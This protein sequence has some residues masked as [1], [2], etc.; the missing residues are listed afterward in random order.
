MSQQQAAVQFHPSS[1]APVV[2]RNI[3]GH[4]AEHLGRCIYEGIWVGE[5]SEIPNTRGIRNDVVAALRQLNIPVLRWPGGCF[6][7]EYHWMDGIGPREERPGIYNSHWGGVVETNQFGTHE[8]L[9]LCEMLETDPYICGNVGSGT[10]KE[11]QDWV[12]YMTSDS[13]SPMPNLRRKNGREKAWR[14]PFFGVGNESWGC[15]GNMRPEYYANEYRRYNTFV[16]TYS[17]NKI[18]RIACGANSTDTNWTRVLMENAHTHMDGLALHKYTLAGGK[19]P[20]SGSAIDFTEAGWFDILRESVL[21]EPLIQ[22]HIDEMDKVD[23]EKRVGMVIDEWGTWF[24]VEPGTNPGFLYQQNALRDA[25][26]AAIHFHIFHRHADRISMANIAQTVNV[27]QAMILTNGP[28]MIC[29]PTYWVFEMFKVHQDSQVIPLTITS[30]NYAYAGEEIPAVSASATV[31]DATYVSLVNVDPHHSA[32][33]TLSLADV[34]FQSGRVLTGPTIQAHN[35]FDQP[36]LVKPVE[37]NAITK[38]DGGFLVELPP[39]S[40]AVL[41]FA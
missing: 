21:I 2:N 24:A 26:S 37:F 30:D 25:V 13:N 41:R 35:T 36:D 39:A 18:Y 14:V 28:Q 34:S 29:T 38:T 23:P 31:S 17:D 10:V 32:Q 11:M 22:S 40:V 20:P 19:W 33:I 8:F 4:F 15:G 16:R 3:Y 12:E 7:D 27:L 1:T 6:A 9:D 5:D